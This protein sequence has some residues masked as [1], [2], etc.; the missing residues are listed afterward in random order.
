[1]SAALIALASC[2]KPA[3]DAPVAPPSPQARSPT[4]PDPLARAQAAADELG[5]TMRG[6]L[7]A[8]M[9]EGGP[10][11]AVEVCSSEAPTIAA[12]IAGRTKVRVGRASL[13]M[14]GASTAPDW[15]ASWLR[16]QGERPAEGVVGFARVEG[17]HARVLRPIPI[18]APCLTCHG[19]ELAPEIAKLLDARYPQDQARGYALGALRGAL[20]AEVDLPANAP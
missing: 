19:Q 11:R 15:V 2:A 16:E 5:R 4:P 1:M 14:R 18:E 8:A 7:Q 9:V 20:W 17:S 3:P 12:E 13:R 10:A 6:R